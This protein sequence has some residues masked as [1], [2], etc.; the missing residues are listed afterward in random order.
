MTAIVDVDDVLLDWSHGFDQWIREKYSYSEIHISQRKE[1][2]FD[3]FHSGIYD[4]FND[5]EGFSSLNE[6]RDAKSGLETLSK[7]Y[8]LKLVSSCGTDRVQ[9]RK[10]NLNQYFSGID[11]ELILLSLHEPKFQYIEKFKPQI[12]IDDNVLNSQ[13]HSDL[14]CGETFL[15]HTEFNSK[16]DYKNIK[17]VKTWKEIIKNL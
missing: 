16:F 10:S 11:Y 9:S 1:R 2:L 8:Q 5:S 4:E 17:R 13:Y 7:N 12:F 14:K 6:I 3:L 15:F